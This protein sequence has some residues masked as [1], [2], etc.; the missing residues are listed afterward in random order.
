MR[1]LPTLRFTTSLSGSL[2][3]HGHSHGRRGRLAN[4]VACASDHTS[5]SL[6]RSTSPPLRSR[7]ARVARRL[8]KRTTRQPRPAALI[9]RRGGRGGERRGRA[10][11]LGARGQSQGRPRPRAAGRGH[12]DAAS[13]PGAPQQAPGR[14]RREPRGQPLPAPPVDW[15]QD[16]SQRPSG[17]APGALKRPVRGPPHRRFA[18]LRC[19]SKLPPSVRIPL[20]EPRERLSQKVYREPRLRPGEPSR[21]CPATPESVR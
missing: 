5:T 13:P 10:T 18:A 16:W 3:A 6:S 1:R 17:V 14:P 12:P 21:R 7:T 15:S 19:P 9:G 2:S 8:W 20:P 11:G 4:S